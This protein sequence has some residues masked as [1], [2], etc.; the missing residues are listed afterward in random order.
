M[1]RLGGNVD[2]QSWT[3]HRWRHLFSRLLRQ[4]RSALRLNECG[5]VGAHAPVRGLEGL[6]PRGEHP[7]DRGKVEERY[8]RLLFPR[9]STPAR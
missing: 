4:R 9:V 5:R 7:A 8:R 6:I 3:R 2:P 1:E